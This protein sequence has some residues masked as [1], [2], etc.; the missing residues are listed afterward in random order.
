MSKGSDL[1]VA[2]R[3]TKGSSES[4]EDREKKVKEV[5]RIPRLSRAHLPG[6]FDTLAHD[7]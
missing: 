3:I 6:I 4:A 7:E 2:A 5:I 1:L